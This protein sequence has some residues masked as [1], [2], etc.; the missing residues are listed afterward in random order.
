M[1]KILISALATVLAFGLSSCSE[2]ALDTA[3]TTAI[4]GDNMFSNATNA[5][6]PL[7]GVYRMLYSTWSSDAHHSFGISAH[8]IVADVMGDDMI[9]SQQGSG[10]FWYECLYD[11]KDAIGSAS[12]RPYDIW[13]IYYTIIANVNYII[14]AK[15]TMGGMPS[16]INYVIGQ[17]YALR[18]YSY[19]I[20]AQY[21]CRNYTDYKGDPGV[22]LYTEPT[23]AGT[24]GKPRGTV[25]DVYAQ[26]NADIDSAVVRLTNSHAQTHPSHID[27]YVANGIKARICLVQ[28]RWQDAVDAARIAQQGASLTRDVLSGMNSVGQADVLW[29]AEIIADQTG[30]YA[31]FFMHMDKSAG[32]GASARKQI[33]KSLYAK[34]GKNDIRRDWWDTSDTGDG[35]DVNGSGYQQMK[36]RWANAASW[37]GDYIWMRVPEMYLIEAEGL[38]MLN[39]EA[40][41]KKVL[42][43][44]MSYRDDDYDCSA[45]TGTALPKV[46]GRDPETGSLREEIINQRRIELWGE[47]GRIYDIRRL[48]QGFVRPEEDGWP[49]AALLEGLHTDNPDTWDWVMTIP[50]AE[51]DANK[52]LNQN[53]DQNPMDSGI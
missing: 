18:A 19:F 4:T 49:I 11:V 47:Y 51:F 26:I 12:W 28:E 15:E 16:D 7:N 50:Q 21:Y 46:N 33:S 14:D 24:E 9:M 29:G 45:L 31:S 22:P 2:E 44:L 38:C 39:D 41:A 13:N 35:N 27:M 40:G 32:Y 34:I 42:G 3:P 6:T 36:F 10:W 52:A 8:N 1:K 25:E 20:L 43:T 5:L 30:G 23:Y 53:T 48:H 37:L 17:A